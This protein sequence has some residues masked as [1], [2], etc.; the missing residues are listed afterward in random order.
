MGHGRPRSLLE[1]NSQ[2]KSRYPRQILPYRAAKGLGNRMWDQGLVL[3]LDLVTVCSRAVEGGDRRRSRRRRTRAIRRRA[4]RTVD[5]TQDGD[6]DLV[7]DIAP[8]IGYTGTTENFQT[9]VYF[10]ADVKTSQRTTSD[11]EKGPFV[12]LTLLRIGASYEIPVQIARQNELGITGKI[13]AH[14]HHAGHGQLELS[15]AICPQNQKSTMISR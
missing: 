8:A 15:C 10:L 13:A 11:F 1:C 12:A 2:R 5:R 14:C 9:S 3:T 7:E 4:T 6:E